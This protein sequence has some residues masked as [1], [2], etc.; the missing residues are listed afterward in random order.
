MV[1]A[2]SA[3]PSCPGCVAQLHGGGQ[4]YPIEPEEYR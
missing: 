4:I 3:F 1:E 2:A